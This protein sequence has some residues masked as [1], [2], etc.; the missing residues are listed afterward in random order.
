MVPNLNF[1]DINVCIHKSNHHSCIKLSRCV[2]FLLALRITWLFVDSSSVASFCVLFDFILQTFAVF[3]LNSDFQAN[4]GHKRI[5]RVS[6][7]WAGLSKPGLC[8]VSLCQNP[9]CLP[10]SVYML[11][12][13]NMLTFFGSQANC[14][15]AKGNKNLVGH[16]Y[17][18]FSANKYLLWH[19]SCQGCSQSSRDDKETLVLLQQQLL[20]PWRQLRNTSA[21]LWT[22]THLV[23]VADLS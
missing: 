3:P 6:V 22:H 19:V 2:N 14:F 17:M 15:F 7:N 23:R 4:H 20:R 18:L 12:I 9:V 21:G 5:R 16:I 13:S 8:D 1:W 11:A 10:G